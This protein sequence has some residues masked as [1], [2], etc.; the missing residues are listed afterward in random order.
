MMEARRFYLAGIALVASAVIASAIPA[1]KTKFVY[2]QPDG[3]KIELLRRGDE[4][5]HW[6]E[7]TS[8]R[9]MVLSEDGYYRPGSEA[10]VHGASIRQ[11]A[12]RKRQ[13]ASEIR[14]RTNPDLLVGERHILV[15]LVNYKDKSF[16]LT[17]PGERFTALLNE[18]GYSADGG[19]GSVRDFYIDNS[20]GKFHPT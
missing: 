2:T 5:Y 14:M 11:R 9:I 18:E 8:G 1:P 6:T 16:S 13:M 17:N 20:G 15:V 12:L 3:S 19:T 4:F 10:E 7:D